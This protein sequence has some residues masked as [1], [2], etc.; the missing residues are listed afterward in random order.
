VLVVDDAALPNQGRLSVGMAREYR[1]ALGKR[2]NC[3]ALVSLTLA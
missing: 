3:Q 2:A 1:G